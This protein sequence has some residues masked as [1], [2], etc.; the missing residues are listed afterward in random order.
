MSRPFDIRSLDGD[1]SF[2]DDLPESLITQIATHP[3][4]D[5]DKRV[6]GVS[7][8]RRALLRGELPD[9]RSLP[10]PPEHIARPLLDTIAELGVVRFCAGEEELT[11]A[12]ITDLLSCAAAAH[13][14]HSARFHS[15]LA[16]LAMS[17][18]QA[19]TAAA[20]KT[21]RRQ[22]GPPKHRSSSQ[23][24]AAGGI[25][26]GIG[27][28]SRPLE[29]DASVWERIQAEARQRALAELPALIAAR[30]HDP[31]TERVELWRELAEVFGELRDLMG[32]GWDLSQGVLR[33]QGW[34]ELVRLRQL[35]AGLPALRELIRTLG[36]MHTPERSD[37]PS[38]MEAIFIQMRRTHEDEAE[39]RAPHVPA[40][41]RGVE[42]SGAI[43]R[44]L[45]V[46]AALLTH[47]VLRLL[48]HARRAE[49]ALITYRVEGVYT[50]RVHEE[51]DVREQHQQLRPRPE[52]GPIIACVDTSGSMAGM[53]ELVAKAVALEAMRVAYREQRR[54]YLYGFSGPEQ[55]TEHE[56]DL[57][58]S[59]LASLLA[60]LSC[61]F[62]GGTD[63]SEPLARVMA[64]LDDHAWKR[65]DVLIISDGEM[66]VPAALQARIRVMRDSTESRFHGLRVGGTSSAAMQSICDV[67]HELA[68]WDMAAQGR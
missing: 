65:A 41:T 43:A 5:L 29:L 33:H 68:S 49:N 59:G 31:W 30:L 57:G 9:S 36:R 44:M 17:H 8:W 58:P 4:G 46:E 6:H 26:Q 13:T 63:L 18:R 64:R 24:P 21:S 3:L 51:I 61:S 52:R 48:W 55:V 1:Y 2:L 10:W 23:A 25:G 37:E 45:P 47:P 34:L 54:C 7:M 15:I 38:T 66:A 39:I 62:H 22:Q 60:F 12:L 16:E 67:V 20:A 53:S 42:R 35:I 50:E 14:A 32:I 11:D 56:L 27:L 40:E 19:A 28:S